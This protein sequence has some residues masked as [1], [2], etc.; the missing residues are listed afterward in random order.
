MNPYDW[1]SHHPRIG[2]PR[3]AVEQVAKTLYGG[4]SAVV[5]G[6]RGMGKSVFLQQL[7]TALEQT[8]AIR[9]LLIPTPP[10]ELTVRACLDKLADVLEVAPGAIDSRGIVDG[11]FARGGVAQRLVLLFDEFDRY[12]TGRDRSSGN[13][14]G[15]G[16]FNDLEAT[17]RD[18]PELGVMAT[19]S[20]GVFVARDVLG[21][22]FLSRALHVRLTPFERPQINALVQA[23]AERGQPLSDGVFDALLLA[24]GGIPAL[25][26]YGL[27]RLWELERGASE[28]DV[29]QIYAEF[30]DNHHEY[31]RDLLSSVADPRL[32][33]APQRVLDR[34]RRHPGR[35]ERGELEAACERPNGPLAL[36]LNDTLRLLQAAG[37]VRFTGKFHLTDPVLAHP[38]PSILNLPT[39]SPPQRRWREQFFRDLGTLLEKLH[40]W[41]ADFFRPGR[42]GE[43]KKLVPESVFAAHLALG[44]ELL[45]WDAERE[46]LSAAGRT[47][48]KLRYNG[49][50]EV[51]VIEVKIWGRNDYREA[52]RQVESYWTAEVGAGAVV[53]LTDAE[54]PDWPECYRQECLEGAGV[55]IESRPTSDSPVRARFSCQATTADGMTAHVDHYLLRLSRRR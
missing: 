48:L 26:T 9:V 5:L 16:F 38:I 50:A 25:L 24:S 21:S 49:S 31:L 6:G 36:D 54:I 35:I 23:F 47:D 33:E 44:F 32:S 13:P 51:A 37:L 43:G 14:P 4:G 22:S 19:G 34:I 2:I 20:L 42:G 7:Q 15:R 45:G 8:G 30:C 10:P 29:T 55:T 3:Q 18:V 1:Q 39:A 53:Q 17:R 40:Q 28:R 41:S 27:Q 52:Q 12:A 11:W 46:G